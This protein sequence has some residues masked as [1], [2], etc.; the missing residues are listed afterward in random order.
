MATARLDSLLQ[1]IHKLAGGA[2]NAHWSDRQL[3]DKFVSG[4]D[5]S[6]FSALISRHGPMVLRVC[7]R[8]LHNEQDAEDAF[9]ATFLVLARNSASIRQREALVGWLHGVAYRTAMKAR[10]SA[11]RRRKHEARLVHCIVPSRN[12]GLD[13]ADPSWKEVRV[14]LDEEIQ[15]LP[16]HHRSAF[17][18]C[19]LE[20]KS[21]P[22]AAAELACKAGTVSGWLARARARLRLRL[23][24]RG[25]ELTALLA[26]LAVAE[27]AR[28]GVPMALAQATI[29]FGLWVAVGD[30][31]ART[32]PP[33]MAALA[34]GVTRAMF[35]T[36]T[37]IA[38]AALIVSGLLTAFGF[39]LA[40]AGDEK[41]VE[42]NAKPQAAAKLQAAGDKNSITY[43]G[44]VLDQEA[45]P[46]AGAKL[47]LTLMHGYAREPFPASES[48]TTGPEG[49]FQFT[50]PKAIF[51]DRKTAVAATAL[52]HGIGWAEVPADG[53]RDGVTIRLVKD[54]VPI[55]GLVV[56]LEAKPVAGATLQVLAIQAASKEDIG[57]WLEAVRGKHPPRKQ[58]IRLDGIDL[59]NL[60]LK[61]TTD[62]EGRVRLAGVGRDRL[63]RARLD[64]PTIASQYLDLITRPGKAIEV[65]E[66]KGQP[67]PTIFYA[68]DFRHVAAPTKPVVGVVRDK[69]TGKPLAGV[70]VESNQLANDRTPGNNIVWTMTDA[71]GRYR[72]TGLPTG[73]GNKV[74]LVPRGDQPYVSVHAVV[75]DTVGL[76]AS[77][78]DFE[79]KRG[80]WIV[81]KL[82]DKVTG[83]PVRGSVDYFALDANPNVKDHP[84]F[85]GTIPPHW[86][87]RTKD[88]GSFRIVGLPGPGLVAV[89]YT[90]EHLL[91]PDRDDEYGTKETVSYTSPRQL[92]LLINYTA[93]ARIDPA[94][95]VYAVKRD[96]TLDPGWTINGT[97][98]GPDGKPLAGARAFGLHSRGWSFEAMKTAEFAVQAFN[99]RQPRDVFFRHL[100]KGLVGVAQPP[101][102]NGGA[103]T[104]RMRPGAA[105]TG[106]L[107]DAD[108]RPRASVELELTFRTTEGAVMTASPE[109]VNTD[110]EGRFRIGALLPGY[111]YQLSEGKGGGQ[112]PVRMGLD[113]GKTKELGDVQ[114]KRNGD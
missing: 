109:R 76:D 22:E 56:D 112:F 83:R 14:A 69:G 5:E 15:A 8:V 16:H 95:G 52:N 107:V 78:V 55:T 80:V 70:T 42:S 66:Y 6:A 94:N 48:A 32:I 18:A 110:R 106:R 12:R 98:L 10:R 19:V 104:V 97:V 99:P 108:G 60:S 43:G 4:R 96:I 72:L 65:T 11:A 40:S 46:V 91:A 58:D 73:A 39:A 28:A 54:D 27:N 111:E 113:W 77:T 25:I 84:G 86:G 63:V 33:H 36:K 53:K 9:Q 64:G 34:A 2:R 49:R 20:G 79:L 100:E 81:G 17:V 59:S 23:A 44:R 101:K 38:L 37:K 41:K 57:P 114:T 88:D 87:T 30:T 3:L 92:G 62:A 61:A 71:E 74:R 35:V 51:G 102:E 105:L 75:P 47:Y 24:R 85:V 89:F 67:R 31:A 93:L 7:R 45:K 29:R 68:A 26:A 21:V 50:V 82:T 13:S 90:G 1:H 103:V